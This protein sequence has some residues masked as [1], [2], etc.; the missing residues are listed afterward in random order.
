VL[1]FGDSFSYNIFVY[2]YHCPNFL[3]PLIRQQRN[4]SGEAKN[5]FLLYHTKYC[6]PV[7]KMYGKFIAFVTG[8]LAPPWPLSNL[9]GKK[10]YGV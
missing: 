10:S 1:F 3:K 9:V 2:I 7:K 6:S 4:F 5:T 8:K